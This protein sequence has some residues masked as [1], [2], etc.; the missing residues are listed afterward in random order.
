[1]KYLQRVRL[2]PLELGELKLGRWRHLTPA[3]VRSLT[4]LVKPKPVKRSTQPPVKPKPAKQLA[5]PRKKTEG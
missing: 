3:E 5:K 4:A 1:V 2:G